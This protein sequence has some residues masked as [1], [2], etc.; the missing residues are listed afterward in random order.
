MNLLFE[1]TDIYEF[2]CSVW[3]RFPYYIPETQTI[4]KP[5]RY[6]FNIT[7]R[8][9]LA[10]TYCCQKQSMSGDKTE[11]SC[12]EIL[13]I[14]SKLPWY[15]VIALSGGEP[16]CREDFLE[17]L[18]GITKQKKKTTLLTNGLLLNDVIIC[19]MIQHKMLN[20]GI[21][22]DGDKNYYEKIKGNGNYS[23]LMDKVDSLVYYK[24]KE[25]CLFPAFDWK[26]TVFPENV[27][28]LP[29]LYKQAMNFG[30]NTFTVSLPKKNDFQFSDCLHGLEILDFK[31]ESGSSPGFPHHIYELYKELFAMSKYAKT[32]LRTYPR[33]KHS[34]DLYNYFNTSEIQQR[35]SI[36]REPW[37]GA[38]ISAT[39]EFYPCLSIKVGDMK[40]QSLAQV[41][42]S[43]ENTKFRERLKNN[44]LFPICDGCCYARLKP[45][46]NTGNATHA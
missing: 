35:Y 31:A 15:A 41:L 13:A 20:I 40:K 19:A 16:L 46:S 37:S 44:G 21:A 27:N 32:K 33:L 8:C 26:V 14:I 6:L 34:D 1:L 5:F 38:V 28:Q 7:N 39:G 22:I 43:S 29:L 10:C 42:M 11:L 25:N 17:I 4:F 3:P 36:C 18:K 23:V 30:A 24:K 45:I 2:L 9:N 12:E